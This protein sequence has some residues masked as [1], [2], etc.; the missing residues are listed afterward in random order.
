MRKKYYFETLDEVLCKICELTDSLIADNNENG[1]KPTVLVKAS[2]GM[3]FEKI[4]EKLKL[5]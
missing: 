2:H 4:V 3:H 5:N 1:V